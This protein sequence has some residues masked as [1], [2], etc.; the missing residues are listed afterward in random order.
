MGRQTTP[1][2]R[3]GKLPACKAKKQHN[4]LTGFRKKNAAEPCAAEDGCPRLGNRG[5]KQGIQN[6]ICGGLSSNYDG[7]MPQPVGRIAGGGVWTVTSCFFQMPMYN[8]YL[9]REKR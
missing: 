1:P 3:A 9:V 5:H 4:F 6:G 8:V 2:E 7:A